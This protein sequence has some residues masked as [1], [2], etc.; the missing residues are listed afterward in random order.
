MSQELHDEILPRLF[1]AV[2]LKSLQ[3][4]QA[5]RSGDDQLVR[6]LDRELAPLISEV[7]EYRACNSRE[8]HLQLRFVS[9]LIREDADD[10]SC[11]V[12]NSTILSVLLDRY[13]GTSAVSDV[14]GFGVGN[15]YQSL[16]DDG[17]LNESILNALPDMVAV[18]TTD[19]RYL[20]SN[21]AHGASLKCSPLELV[22]RHISEFM[23]QGLFEDMV[24]ERLDRCFRGECVEYVYLRRE[25]DRGLFVRC[26]LA[27]LKGHDGRVVGAVLTMQDSGESQNMI[28]A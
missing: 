4:Q 15:T 24:R 1:E 11:V 2:S 5:I 16:G 12:R 26:R 10:R 7:V 22:G 19:Y 18:V 20:Y 6:L 3:L 23:E 27:P 21:A 13:F 8:I 28:A 14:A 9:S 25:G 17:L